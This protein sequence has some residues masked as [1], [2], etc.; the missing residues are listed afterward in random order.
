MHFR[1][2]VVQGRDAE[3]DVV[4][5]LSVVA[6]FDLRRVHKAFVVVQY[7]LWKTGRPRGEV[8][9]RVVVVG[10]QDARRVAREVRR[11][12]QVIFREARAAVADVEYQLHTRYLSAD[13]FDAAD[14]FR[15]EE[16][17]VDVREVKAVFYLFRRVA[18]VEGDGEGSGLQD[19]EI[20]R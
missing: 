14:E 5:F 6:L 7:R 12:V 8:Y 17:R 15:S 20:K 3:K 10:E 16:E 19:A 4:M 1:A 18:E 9:R 11:Q 2:G 13:V